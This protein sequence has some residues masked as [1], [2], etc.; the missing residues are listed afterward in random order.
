[1]TTRVLIAE[2]QVAG[3][4]DLDDIGVSIPGNGSFDLTETLF[5]WEVQE[6]ADLFA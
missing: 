3:Q 2:N 1:M 6:S 5:V 4:I